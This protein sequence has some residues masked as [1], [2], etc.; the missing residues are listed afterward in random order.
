M[1]S[2]DG[3]DEKSGTVSRDRIVSKV[4]TVKMSL[5]NDANAS[6]NSESTSRDY[7]QHIVV[8]SGSGMWAR[9]K[10]NESERAD[11]KEDPTVEVGSF[12]GDRASSSDNSK[13]TVSLLWLELP[14]SDDPTESIDYRIEDVFSNRSI[15][16][17]NGERIVHSI[18]F[19]LLPRVT[20]ADGN[21][22]VTQMTADIS[23]DRYGNA[24]FTN[25]STGQFNGVE[26]FENDMNRDVNHLLIV[27]MLSQDGGQSPLK[28]NF[29]KY[30]AAAIK[31][32][33]KNNQEGGKGSNT[34]IENPGP[35]TEVL[36]TD[37][38]SADV[39]NH[40]DGLPSDGNSP[41]DDI[42]L[43][44]TSGI[45]APGTSSK[46]EPSNENAILYNTIEGN[47][48]EL[49][50]L[51][52]SPRFRNGP[53][54]CRYCKMYRRHAERRGLAYPGRID[55]TAIRCGLCSRTGGTQFARKN[56]R[57]LTDNH[58]SSP[59][60]VLES[61]AY[62]WPPTDFI[63]QPQVLDICKFYEAYLNTI[64]PTLRNLSPLP[65]ESSL[66]NN[67]LCRKDSE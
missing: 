26:L 33:V 58:L 67:R 42:D 22:I 39:E 65:E 4:I 20:A 14:D 32:I 51:R 37:R 8:D 60:P 56:H 64:F 35:S 34:R 38:S 43:P 25:L 5:V 49:V 63:R 45:D 17:M 36:Q 52:E 46:T 44:S 29:N 2:Q 12:E 28:S 48:S 40:G 10:V 27:K 6:D 41:S 11:S 50:P 1:D 16:D 62:Y 30:I 61:L 31:S 18:S 57:Y 59:T 24:S 7:V 47:S 66:K 3:R 53:T 13:E 9:V 55:L 19:V 21:R 15:T 23:Y 54:R